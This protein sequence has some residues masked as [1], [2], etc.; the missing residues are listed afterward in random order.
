MIV[1][2]PPSQGFFPTIFP[3]SKISAPS[4][5]PFRQ[6]AHPKV[7]QVFSSSMW[8]SLRTTQRC[9]WVKQGKSK[10]KEGYKLVGGFNPFDTYQI[11]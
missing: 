10:S 11:Y 8:V 6:I 4:S 9:E 2:G 1:K 5:T 7:A 3:M